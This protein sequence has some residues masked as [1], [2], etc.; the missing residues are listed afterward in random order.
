[1]AK[2]Y[3]RAGQWQ[4]PGYQDKGAE[5]VDVPTS[6][7][8]LA[9]WLQAR[10]V[11]ADPTVWNDDDDETQLASAAESTADL[12]VRPQTEE[13]PRVSP[14]IARPPS[15]GELVEFVLDGATVAEVELI[16]SAIGTRFAELRKEARQ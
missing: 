10:S 2:L 14:A 6:P 4:V 15:C 8:T 13:P 1:M 11:K 5:R 16:F 9:S 7:E 3:Y 12:R